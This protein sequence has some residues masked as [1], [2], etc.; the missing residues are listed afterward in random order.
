MKDKT[1]IVSEYISAYGLKVYE[2]K[3]YDKKSNSWYIVGDSSTDKHLIK[4]EV[5]IH[6]STI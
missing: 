4:V 6:N 1:Q 2:A 5:E 3:Q